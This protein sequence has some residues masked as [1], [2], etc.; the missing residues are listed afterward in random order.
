MLIESQT[1]INFKREYEIQS[2]LKYK[3]KFEIN[4]FKLNNR[5][6]LNQGTRTF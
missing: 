4:N 3:Q 6:I 1:I 2:N 5:Q